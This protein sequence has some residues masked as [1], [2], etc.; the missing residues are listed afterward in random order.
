MSVSA[1]LLVV[2]AL[3]L[4]V[5]VVFTLLWRSA[6][7]QAADDLPTEWP[8]VQRPLFSPEER[9]LYRQL[10]AALPHHMILAKVPL[11]RFCQPVD[12]NDV[13]YWFG[14]L[15]PI[16]VSFII[17]ADNGRVLAA[18]DIKRPDFKPSRRTTVIKQAVLTACRIR[19]IE[20]RSDQLPSTSDLQGI[21][22]QQ[23]E[24]AARTYV[25]GAG[26]AHANAPDRAS[27]NAPRN[28]AN[29]QQPSATTQSGGNGR[30]T[31]AHAVRTPRSGTPWYESGFSQDSF[32]APDLR[33]QS[34][35]ETDPSAGLSSSSS[36]FPSFAAGN[37]ADLQSHRQWPPHASMGGPSSSM[38][39]SAPQDGFGEP[40][41]AFIRRR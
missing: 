9:T 38:T 8:L 35:P 19:Y 22:P 34:F 4:L 26:Q 17:C 40:Q 31:L 36:R 7:K 18:L 2:V 15:G 27:A 24:T 33:D 20:C 1:W 6:R 39:P 14:L 5:V 25:P 41:P 11:V 23:G 10:R 29:Q 37:N 30:S 13:R 16:H 28:S 12:R 21:V 32:F 3:A